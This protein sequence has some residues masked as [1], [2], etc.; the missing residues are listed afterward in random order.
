MFWIV[1]TVGKVRTRAQRQSSPD[2]HRVKHYIFNGT[3]RLCRRP[4]PATLAQVEMYKAELSDLWKKGILEVRQGEPYGP[5]FE[6][7]EVQHDV[8]EVQAEVTHDPAPEAAAEPEP[9]EPEVPAA[10]PEQEPDDGDEDVPM[11]EPSKPIERMNKQELVEYALKVVETG[12]LDADREA[13]EDLTKA[14]IKELLI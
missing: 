11:P 1:S 13:L 14:E 9:A 7:G 12:Y 8:P 6:F 5:L 4:V 2:R 3:V 10:E